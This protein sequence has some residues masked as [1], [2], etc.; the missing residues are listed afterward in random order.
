MF[1]A[2]HDNVVRVWHVFDRVQ[3]RFFTQDAGLLATHCQQAYLFP[4]A[5]G[6][7]QV[8][9]APLGGGKHLDNLKIPVKAQLSFQ[10]LTIGI[11]RDGQPLV[12][13]LS[14][15]IGRSLAQM[16]RRCC[17]IE[18]GSVVQHVIDD[19]LQDGGFNARP[20]VVKKCLG[21]GG[22]HGYRYDHGQRAAERRAGRNYPT[23]IRHRQKVTDIFN[24]GVWLV[25]VPV[26]VIG[27]A[28]AAPAV[29]TQHASS[30]GQTQGKLVKGLRILGDAG[31]TEDGWAAAP[32][33]AIIAKLKFESILR[34]KG[35]LAAAQ[36]GNGP[37]RDN[38]KD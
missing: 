2:G 20:E 10:R 11:A 12:A 15:Q 19:R 21:N 1:D 25:P 17:P 37:A 14:D 31:Q 8:G 6:R 22:R 13:N 5:K 28:P 18:L 34:T 24:V 3:E 16:T 29:G 9:G 7:S 38:R 36:W 26:V 33:V 30:T 35:L 32:G 23:N 4:G 27:G